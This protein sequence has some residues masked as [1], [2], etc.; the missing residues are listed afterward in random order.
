MVRVAQRFCIDRYEDIL[1]DADTGRRLSPY[2]NPGR[3][4]ALGAEKAAKDYRPDAGTESDAAAPLAATMAVPE[5]PAWQRTT[6]AVPKAQSAPNEVP[7]A[8]V[9][10]RQA[11]TACANAHK[12]L[13]SLEEWR[14]A[15]A[16]EASAKFPYGDSYQQGACNIFA[17][18]HPTALL[19][20]SAA[21]GQTDPRVNQVEWKG[22]TLLQ[23]T[24]ETK[25]C[26]SVWGGDAVY[27]MIGN[28]VEWVGTPDGLVYVGGQYA[29]SSRDGC[30]IKSW[31]PPTPSFAN[32]ATGVR[33]C[34]DLTP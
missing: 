14:T 28:L 13:C 7:N 8:N 9:S 33:C 16:G 3:S 6:D 2:Y 18:A 21:V 22:R 15:C 4:T 27:D 17:E 26:K 23:N 10:G 25:T 11:E 32:F 20:G 5:L 24:G 1:V 31:T 30:Q 34:A 19:Y 12:R 29:Q